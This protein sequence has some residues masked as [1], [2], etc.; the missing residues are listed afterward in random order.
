M[1][2][3]PR[4]VGKVNQTAFILAPGATRLW[5]RPLR[6]RTAVD[7]EL[8]HQT[9]ALQRADAPKAR[10][11][12]PP[13]RVLALASPS[14]HRP[15]RITPRCSAYAPGYR[16]SSSCTLSPSPSLRSSCLT[17]DRST[18]TPPFYFVL[19]VSATWYMNRPCLYCSFL[20]SILVISLYDWS[21][22]WFEPRRTFW[23]EESAS[24]GHSSGGAGAGLALADVAHAVAEGIGR[25]V[26]GEERVV[27]GA[28]WLRE[29]VGRR[30]WRIPCLEIAI[31]L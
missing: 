5:T 26:L 9:L 28:Q 14:T 11:D 20:L 3:E 4:V 19:F 1:L 30:E 10:E 18:N 31:R 16:C 25:R 24:R 21:G 22:N 13:R 2:S 27:S 15:A 29:L 6:S 17:T 23:D 8:S 12:A 7:I